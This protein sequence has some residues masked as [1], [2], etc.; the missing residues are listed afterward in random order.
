MAAGDGGAG[1]QRTASHGSRMAGGRRA[2][3]NPSSEP[4][5]ASAADHSATDDGAANLETACDKHKYYYN[6]YY[7]NAETDYG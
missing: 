7:H 2:E 4:R 6:N 1:R 3:S 5:E